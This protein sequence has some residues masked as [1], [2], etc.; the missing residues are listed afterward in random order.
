MKTK[1]DAE[2]PFVGISGGVEPATDEQTDLSEVGCVSCPT[3]LPTISRAPTAIYV[4]TTKTALVA[5]VHE[6]FDNPTL[7]TTTYGH[8]ST[9]DTSGVT[10]MAGLF[11]G[12]SESSCPSGTYHVGARTFNDD[13][14]GWDARRAESESTTW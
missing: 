6:W 4:F 1:E 11:C 10:D 9:W 12:R 14:S 5:A 3:P 2:E 7:A 13:I 8:I